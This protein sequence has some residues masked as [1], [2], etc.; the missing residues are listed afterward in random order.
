M[1]LLKKIYIY[2]WKHGLHV[3]WRERILSFIFFSFSLNICH[4]DVPVSKFIWF[5]SLSDS[6]FFETYCL[7]ESFKLCM[8]C[9][10]CISIADLYKC[11]IIFDFDSIVHLIIPKSK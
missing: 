5:L 1:G 9:A 11:N 7:N 2:K 10:V 4:S 6:I 3:L 8:W